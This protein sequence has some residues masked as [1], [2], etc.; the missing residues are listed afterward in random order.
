MTPYGAV[1]DI[2]LLDSG[3]FV[4]S[5]ETCLA[6]GPA[7]VIQNENDLAAHNV[8]TIC[9]TVRKIRE[10]LRQ[11]RL[12][13]WIDDMLPIHQKWFPDSRLASSWR[14]LNA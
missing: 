6:K 4:C 13:S 12:T 8:W 5:C 3:E 1:K 9:M 2:A 14:I 10:L 7:E 11:D